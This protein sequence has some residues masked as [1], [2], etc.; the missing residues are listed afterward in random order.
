MTHEIRTRQELLAIFNGPQPGSLNMKELLN[1]VAMRVGEDALGDKEALEAAD[2]AARTD[3][4]LLL[5]LNSPGDGGAAIYKRVASEPVGDDKI[6]SLDGAW[7]E[8]VEDVGLDFAS[9]AEAEAGAVDDKVMSP[10][11]SRDHG[12]ARYS[13][14]DHA[15]TLSDV[16]DSGEAAALDRATQAEAR[17]GTASDVVMTPERVRDVTTVLMPTFYAT[18][19][20]FLDA[21]PGKRGYVPAGTYSFDATLSIKANTDLELHPEAILRPS[22]DFEFAEVEDG[23]TVATSDVATPTLTSTLIANA[24]KG[25]SVL[26]VTDASKFTVGDWVKIR[27]DMRVSDVVPRTGEMHAVR[28]VDTGADT[29]TLEEELWFDYTTANGG[30]VDVVE[31]HRD[32][33]LSG[34]VWD[35]VNL[36]TGTRG[37]V[38]QQVL[39][40][41]LS[42]MRV[43]NFERKGIVILDCLHGSVKDCLFE[44][45]GATGIG[46]AIMMGNA[47][48]WFNIK[49]NTSI[50]CAKFWDVSGQSNNYGW[51]RHI[52]V[53]DNT[54]YS[55]RRGGISSHECAEYITVRDN[56]LFALRDDTL[57]AAIYLRSTNVTITKNTVIGAGT[58]ITGIRVRNQ[59]LAGFVEINEN[60]LIDGAAAAIDVTCGSSPNTTYTTSLTRISICDNKIVGSGNR[61][62]NLLWSDSS[63]GR[64]EH[65]AINDNQIESDAQSIMLQLTTAVTLGDLQ[66]HDNI[67]DFGG[68]ASA[69]LEGAIT[70][71][72]LSSNEIE[73]ALFTGNMTRGG[74]YGIRA[75]TNAPTEAFEFNNLIDSS[76]DRVSGY[77]SELQTAQSE[78]RGSLNLTPAA[79]NTST[80]TYVG[81]FATD[82]TNAW[83]AV[84]TASTADWKRIDN[85]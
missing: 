45:I 73:R 64:T 60:R 70:T 66:V 62:I 3:A 82:G 74:V 55:A 14:L 43:I 48:Q 13:Q 85:V 7:W 52:E 83:I 56:T 44:D 1:S 41:H 37:I 63:T 19:Q 54:I 84:G 61:G 39:G 46:Y 77:G 65:V 17:T 49:D 26:S 80:P 2:V 31:M 58:D 57:R 75:S 24:S 8:K 10:L 27:A 71:R 53:A 9:E 29:I 42:N 38:F 12:D 47:T 4:L 18:F 81:Q 23:P 68:T 36:G 22:G 76:G 6:Q 5:G 30:A 15:H 16:S 25:D 69:G 28:A 35:G 72:V 40:L 33:K 11:R 20:D 79:D 34:G 51:T 21:V 78:M 50:R 32:I 59:S 67:C